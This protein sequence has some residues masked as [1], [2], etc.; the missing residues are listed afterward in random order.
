MNMFFLDALVLFLVALDPVSLATPQ[1]WYPSP[2][3]LN[4]TSLVL[5]YCRNAK[6]GHG[7]HE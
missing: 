7:D 2:I 6:W 4:S 1:I 5:V 3:F